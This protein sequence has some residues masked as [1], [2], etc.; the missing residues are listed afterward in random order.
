M[1]P[2]LDQIQAVCA[3]RMT[4]LARMRANCSEI[5]RTRAPSSESDAELFNAGSGR[6]VRAPLWV[7]PMNQVVIG[8]AGRLT[9]T[10]RAWIYLASAFRTTRR[11]QIPQAR[12]LIVGDGEEAGADQRLG[13]ARE[14]SR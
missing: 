11:A 9:R 7:G 5:T 12:L 3:Q 2:L 14:I 4:R 1:K 10:Q 13:Y 6:T 8:Y